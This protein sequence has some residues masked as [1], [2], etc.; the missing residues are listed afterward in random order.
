MTAAADAIGGHHVE[1]TCVLGELRVLSAGDSVPMG[2]NSP[3]AWARLARGLRVRVGGLL[4]PAGPRP[5]ARPP[6]YT[7]A[8]SIK[9]FSITCS[10]S[11]SGQNLN[12]ETRSFFLFFLSKSSLCRYSHPGAQTVTVRRRVT[13]SESSGTPRKFF[14]GIYLVLYTRYIH[15]PWICQRYTWYILITCFPDKIL[16][17]S[18]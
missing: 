8:Y 4:A 10:S 6:W 9:S 7:Q 15:F 18:I 13:E 11:P 5:G 16:F 3:A 2:R 17:S 14:H 12:N 1:R